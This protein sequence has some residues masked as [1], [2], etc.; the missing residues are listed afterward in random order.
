M[1]GVDGRGLFAGAPM[2][3]LQLPQALRKERVA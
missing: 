1:D 2:P 3:D